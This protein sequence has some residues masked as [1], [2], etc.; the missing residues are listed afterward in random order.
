MGRNAADAQ[1]SFASTRMKAMRQGSV[2]RLTQ[3]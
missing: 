1:G 3:A 2:P